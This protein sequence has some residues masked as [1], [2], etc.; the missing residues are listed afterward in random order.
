MSGNIDEPKIK[1]K[2]LL[3]VAEVLGGDEKKAMEIIN[4]ML[5]TLMELFDKWKE[6]DRKLRK[7]ESMRLP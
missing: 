3:A 4:L 1:S 5:S 7:I 6:N 2:M